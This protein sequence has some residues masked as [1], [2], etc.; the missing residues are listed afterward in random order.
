MIDKI[1]KIVERL[2]FRQLLLIMAVIFVLTYIKAPFIFFQQDEWLGF[3]LIISQGA[4]IIIR[5]LGTNQTFHFIPINNLLEYL[6]YKYFGL[7]YIAYNI[8]G[9]FF[10]LLNGYLI[11]ELSWLLFKKK[12]LAFTSSAIFICS[13]VAY[14][15]ILWPLV[16]LNTLSL[17]FTLLSWLLFCR[18]LGK[19]KP[20]WWGILLAILMACSILTLEYAAGLL[21]FIPLT[22]WFFDRKKFKFIHLIPLGLLVALY[23]LVRFLP[24]TAVVPKQGIENLPIKLLDYL[25]R[26]LSQLFLGDNYL[27]GLSNLLALNQKISALKLSEILA[28][29]IGFFI[30]IFGYFKFKGSFSKQLLMSGLF[31]ICSVLPFIII[32]GAS[33]TFYTFPPRYM[34]FGLAGFS[35]FLVSILSQSRN[36]V[37]FILIFL[38]IV[39]GIGNNLLFENDLKYIGDVRLSILENI[40]YH[41]PALPKKVIFYITSDSSYYGLPEDEKI[42]PFQSGFGQTLLIWYHLPIQFYSNRF[43]WN[44]TDQGYEEYN[45]RGFGYFRD[46][47]LLIEAMNSY[48][49]PTDSVIS[50]TWNS[51]INYLK[52][53]TIQTRGS[54]NEF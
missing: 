14:Q 8:V 30:I 5:G 52:D 38:Y 1:E 34:Y 29:F 32:P 19:S 3:G 26:Y 6:S 36:M 31:I 18:Y 11:F 40:K 7:N 4:S 21:L 48:N 2:E 51:K 49:L 9:L 35:I 22:Y 42:L 23:S 43:L 24:S 25:P 13:S 16:S 20:W 33:G 46:K 45:G 15:L 10:H 47:K 54:L 28:T 37:I 50:F 12:F 39:M 27:S 44:I 41:Y 17:S 53:T